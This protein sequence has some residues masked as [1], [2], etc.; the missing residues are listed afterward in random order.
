MVMRRWS[1]IRSGI[2]VAGVLFVAG[3]YG[4]DESKLLQP[5]TPAPSFSLPSL[6]GSRVMLNVWCGQ[7]LA[8]PY[9][10]KIRHVVIVSYWAT[11][12]KPC[13]KEIPELMKFMEKHTADSVKIFCISID[14]EGATKVKPFV[15]EKN[16]TVPVLLDPYQK[17]AER[18]GVKSLPALFVVGPDGVIRFSSLGFEEGTSLVDKLES[19]LTSIRT[20]QEITVSAGHGEAVAVEESPAEPSSAPGAASPAPAAAPATQKP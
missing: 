11:Y 14:K 15:V 6:D 19:I 4:A 2:L 10:N 3:A 18:Y 16:Y 17:T 8:K 5:G 20:G 9:L 1:G 12:C 13:Q 7:T